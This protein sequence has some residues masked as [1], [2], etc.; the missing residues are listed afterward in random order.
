MVQVIRLVA[1]DLD[2]TLVRT[3]GTISDRTVAALQGVERSGGTVVFVTG[4]PPRWMAEVASA[5]G[6]TGLAVCA[7]GALL[8]DLHKEEVVERFPLAA[9]A[10]RE[11]VRVLRNA[12][13]DISFA[14]ESE[15]G[16]ALEPSYRT[17]YSLPADVR[18]A[19]VE[20]LLTDPVVKLL[21]RSADRSSDELLAA[22]RDVLGDTVT[23]THSTPGG[24]GALLEI[25]AAGV[26][27]A[28]TLARLC[29][30][31]G[32]RS[33]EVVAFGDMPNDLP[34]LAW[35]GTSYAVANAHAD[36]LAAVDRTTASNDDDGVALVLEEL[37]PARA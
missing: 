34:M 10:A 14:V 25:S 1:S 33:E 15:Q 6:H 7:N 28:T 3:D 13:Q 32:V 23:A 24:N 18:V 35:A 29:A 37:F 31:R 8:Y 2:G 20:E 4:R 19:A 9:E 16:F 22:A 17:R 30:E 27:K 36:V 11:T 21:V 5:T 26:S 12:M